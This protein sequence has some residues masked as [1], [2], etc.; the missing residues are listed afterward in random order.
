MKIIS[1]II[2]LLFGLTASAQRTVTFTVVP[3]KTY[4]IQES[5]REIYIPSERTGW[6]YFL[7]DSTD[8][9]RILEISRSMM[10]TD[11]YIVGPMQSPKPENPQNGILYM[12][13]ADHPLHVLLMYSEDRKSWF[14]IEMR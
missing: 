9:G 3:G 13:D 6:V 10:A 14:I 12:M 5:D 8:N 4:E 1:I 7:P 11:V 2:L